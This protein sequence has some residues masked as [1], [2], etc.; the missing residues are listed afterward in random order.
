MTF[1]VGCGPPRARSIASPTPADARSAATLQTAAAPS[2]TSTVPPT[3][4]VTSAPPQATKAPLTFIEDDYDRARSEATKRGLLIFVD[5]WADWCHTCMSLREV[6]FPDEKL[7]AIADRFVWL[8]ID[9]ENAKNEPFLARFP[10]RTLPT[11]WVLDPKTQTPLLKW[12][13]AATADELVAV[14]EDASGPA[15][16]KATSATAL[17]IQANRE[18][19]VGHAAKASP[20]YERALA[21]GGTDWP[22]RPRAIEALTMRFAELG[23]AKDCLALSLLEAPRMPVGTSRVNVVVNGM[24]AASLLPPTAS[25]ESALATLRALAEHIAEDPNPAVLVDDRSSLYEALVHTYATTNPNEAR[26][27]A[28]EWAALLEHAAATDTTKEARRARDPHRLEAYL[29]LG[30]PERAIPML[31]ESEREAP[32]DENPPARLARARFAMGALDQAL[33]DVNRALARSTGPR[34]LRVYMLEAD[35]LLAKKNPA[36]ARDALRKAVEF[37]HE[38]HLPAQYDRLVA[39]IAKKMREL[40]RTR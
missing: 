22:K 29:A 26:R 8:S 15:D 30:Q 34:K 21:L 17:F 14:L 32:D 10:G 18:S 36:S 35:I 6:V 2:A 13:G 39:S 11:L 23:R 38:S 12:I 25:T 3:N 16:E 19:A 4:T 20:L 37:A 28:I 27:L 7:A 5:I 31:E 33:A 24:E 9:S 1:L 40:P